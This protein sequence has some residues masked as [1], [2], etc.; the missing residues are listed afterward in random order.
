M[1]STMR[2]GLVTGLLAGLVACAAP[3]WAEIRIGSVLS[4]TGPAGFLGT[5]EKKTLEMY[6]EQINAKGGIKGEKI[7]LVVY[8]DGSK[9]DQART[10]ATRL[11]E[12]DKVI[13]VVG[14]TS[15]GASLAMLPVFE[16][17]KTPF[18]SLSGGVQIVD[19]VRKYTFKPP[20]TDIMACQKI[21]EDMKKRNITRVAMIYGTDGFAMSMRASCQKA[22]G[23]Y[24]IKIEHEESY[25]PSDADVTPQLAN[26]KKLA[27]I[28]AV[29]SP[30]IGQGPAIVTRNYRQVGLT[31]PLYL[32]HGAATNGFIELAGPAANGVRMPGPALL[33]ANELPNSD[34]QK[35]VLIDYTRAYEA[36]AKEPVSAFGGYA[37]DG[38]FLLVEAMQRAGTTNRDRIRDE[39]EKTRNFMGTVG[40]IT[41]SPTDHLGITLAAFRMIEIRDGK[42]KLSE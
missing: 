6:V 16:E 5:P 10:F 13:A 4:V 21:F 12:D 31:Q 8:D 40:S 24:G 19:P 28:Q 15:T 35:K 17:A 29:L 41:M 42:W 14:G 39:I 18:V 30:G 36:H 9:A 11:V 27:G 22:Q 33:V 34:P 37:Y 26:I 32:S 23:D 3:A 2:D 25:G 38:L 20:Q 7:K 1:R